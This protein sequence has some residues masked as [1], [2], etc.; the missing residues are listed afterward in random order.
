MDVLRV[1]DVMLH[2]SRGTRS[3]QQGKVGHPLVPFQ[4]RN[5]YLQ[6]N[7]AHSM[8]VCVPSTLNYAFII[9]YEKHFTFVNIAS[10]LICSY[11]L[12]FLLLSR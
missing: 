4:C 5:T 12:R 7:S 2:I 11:L 1:C 6:S 8:R 9:I 3:G 10:I